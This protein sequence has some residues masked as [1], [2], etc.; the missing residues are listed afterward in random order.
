LGVVLAGEFLDANCDCSNGDRFGVKY[1]CVVLDEGELL[2]SLA[3][4]IVVKLHTWSCC[5][6]AS[7]E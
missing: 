5:G 4:V 2:V 6:R 7:G 1:N 3:L